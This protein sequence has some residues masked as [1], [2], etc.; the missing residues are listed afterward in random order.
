MGVSLDS[1]LELGHGLSE[2]VEGLK[3]GECKS[4]S[5]GSKFLVGCCT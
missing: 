4:V 3:A 5:L 1:I 2:K